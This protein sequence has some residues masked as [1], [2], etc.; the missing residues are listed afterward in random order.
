MFHFK[1]YLIIVGL[2]FAASIAFSQG[3][4]KNVGDKLKDKATTALNNATT[5]EALIN[6]AVSALQKSYAKRDSASMSLALSSYDNV[7]FYSDRKAAGTALRYTTSLLAELN[8]YEFD[9]GGG[10]L[11]FSGDNSNS[12]DNLSDDEYQTLKQAETLNQSGE[13]SYSSRYFNYAKES[14]EQASEK[15]SSATSLKNSLL[16]AKV[17]SNL[18]MLSHTLGEYNNAENYFKECNGILRNLKGVDYQKAVTLNNEAILLRDLGE[19]ND[20]EDKF[21]QSIKLL[22]PIQKKGDSRAIVQNNLA[23]LYQYLGRLDESI[24]ILEEII[25]D[26]E[27]NWNEKSNT[28]QRINI[29]LALIYENAGQTEKAENIYL[30]ALK[31]KERQGR[32]RQPDYASIL[33][34]LSSLYL[35]SGQLDKDIESNLNKAEQIYEKEY[36]EEH[37]TIS[38]VLNVKGTYQ[39]KANQ[40]AAGLSTLKRNYELTKKIFGIKHPKVNESRI[41]L[42]YAKWLNGDTRG[43]KTDFKTSLDQNIDYIKNY[44]PA[45]SEVEKSKYWQTLQSDFQM[46]YAFVADKPDVENIKQLITYEMVVKGLLLSTSGK[47]RQQIL[48]SNDRNLIRRYN[49]WKESKTLLAYYYTLSPEDLETQKVNL[50]SMVRVSNEQERWLSSNSDVFKSGTQQ[51]SNSYTELQGKLSSTEALVDVIKYYDPKSSSN[52]YAAV[53]IRST[54]PSI[55]KIN[56]EETLDGRAIK[57]YKNAIIYK[58][59]EDKSYTSFWKPIAPKLTGVKKVYVVKDGAYNQLSTGTLYNGSKY[60]AELYDFSVLTNPSELINIKSASSKISSVFLMGSPAFDLKKFTPLPG[61]EE[62]VKSIKSLVSQ[63]GLS[64]NAYLQGEATEKN[65]DN[66]TQYNVLHVATHGFFIE[67]KKE[68]SKLS[69]E[70]VLSANALDALMR[71]GLVLADNQ[72]NTTNDLHKSDDGMATAYE[73]SALDFPSTEI[74]ILSACETGLGEIQ[75][76]EG[77]YGLQ[78]SFLVAGA[79]SVIMSLWKVDDTATKDFMIAFYKQWLSSGNKFLAFNAAKREIKAKY[80]EPYYWGAFVLIEG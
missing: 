70:K 35:N 19:F 9:R 20:S 41:L 8:D 80:A 22:E 1:S 75:T 14:F 34:N 71:S 53:I 11:N 60:L 21:K 48:A 13:L 57:L 45:M 18:G 61:T 17:L 51:K 5:E 67:K 79:N 73:I 77:V 16:N 74:V 56:S 58:Q 55:V 62:E 7:S 31:L 68:S 38:S 24:A 50:D 27:A 3:F 64:V 28:Y 46:Y 66:A 32:T 36:G 29:N 78:R 25:L 10:A 2:F 42:A 39:L 26:N 54:G 59:Q 30:K 4:L 23:I 69:G 12:Y 15:L 65:F 33:T 52:Q 76:G 37:V 44:F 47:I 6:V 63:K 40:N 49:S 72:K 43:A